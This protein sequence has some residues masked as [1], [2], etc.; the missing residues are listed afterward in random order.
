MAIESARLLAITDRPFREVLQLVTGSPPDL[1]LV[2][3]S[4]QHP[5]HSSIAV[6]P[7]PGDVDLLVRRSSYV[8]DGLVLSRHVSFVVASALS[9]GMS[10]ALRDANMDLSDV[11]AIER[12]RK[13]DISFGSAGAEGCI[14]EAILEGF[15]EDGFLPEFLWRRYVGMVRGVPAFV[16]LEAL[17]AQLPAGVRAKSALAPRQVRDSEAE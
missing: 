7:L 2:S 1:V 10:A 12:V 5:P 13:V 3:Q 17:A 4:I 15:G 8:H 9:A 14:E 6:P 11:V 16:V